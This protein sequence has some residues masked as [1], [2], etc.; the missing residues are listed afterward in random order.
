MF[1]HR[2]AGQRFEDSCSRHEVSFYDTLIGG[3]TVLT[4]SIAVLTA[5]DERKDVTES[6]PHGPPARPRPLW[7]P[8][9][10]VGWRGTKG[11]GRGNS[12]ETTHGVQA[13]DG[14]EETEPSFGFADLNT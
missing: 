13:L 1:D 10:P 7:R 12:S 8:P 9:P 2:V 3:P 5:P 6:E 11:S 4:F 14:I